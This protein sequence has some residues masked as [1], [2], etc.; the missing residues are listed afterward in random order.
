MVA[1]RR[2]VTVRSRAGS[3]H[4][5]APTR[6]RP[7]AQRYNPPPGWEVPAGED[8]TPPLDWQPDP[9]WP[10]APDGWI[11]W[12]ELEQKAKHRLKPK[13]RF[14]RTPVAVIVIIALFGVGAVTQSL[15]SQ[16]SRGVAL[17][18]IPAPTLAGDQ[19]GISSPPQPGATKV[20]TTP[21]ATPTIRPTDTTGQGPVG[22]KTT[23]TSTPTRPPRSGPARP[24]ETPTDDCPVQHPIRKFFGRCPTPTR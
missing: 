23:P 16:G 19:T 13:P 11:F 1:T 17:P 6:E 20:G 24:N 2:R 9:S 18:S 5:G 22:R 4:G 8:W 12:L 3:T 14:S 21:T 7:L 15:K 10:S